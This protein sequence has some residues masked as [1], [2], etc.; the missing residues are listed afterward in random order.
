[1]YK[2]KVAKLLE[3]VG[4]SKQIKD[5]LQITDPDNSFQ[6]AEPLKIDIDL[7]S[8]KDSILLKGRAEMKLILDCARCN[9]PFEEP[10]TFSF[11]EVYKK[12][13]DVLRFDESDKE[14]GPEDL[15]FIIEADD[16]IDIEEVLRQNIITALP[17][18][19]ICSINCKPVKLS[20]GEQKQ[21]KA[22]ANLKNLLD[23]KG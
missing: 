5:Q 17:I 16:T 13:E 4:K 9:Q 10:I 7:I 1:M 12:E 20:I 15:Y 23:R 11:E 21:E 2:I 18:K 14:L 19:P 8:L 22:F 6:L 3:E